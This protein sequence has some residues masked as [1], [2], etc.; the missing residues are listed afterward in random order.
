MLLYN[1]NTCGGATERL[2]PIGARTFLLICVTTIWIR[3]YDVMRRIFVSWTHVNWTPRIAEPQQRSHNTVLYIRTLIW[4]N[5]TG[6]FTKTLIRLHE[7]FLYYCIICLLISFL[8]QID[9]SKGDVEGALED[10]K[11]SSTYFQIITRDYK[12]SVH[13]CAHF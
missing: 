12:V 7:S 2:T 4:K 3:K 5:L 9:S 10:I 8:Y 6:R 1:Y 13:S 11:A